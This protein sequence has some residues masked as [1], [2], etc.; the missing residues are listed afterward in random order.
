MASAGLGEWPITY[1][2]TP[3]SAAFNV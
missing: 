1:E 3:T 2:V